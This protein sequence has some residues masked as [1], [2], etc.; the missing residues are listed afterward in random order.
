MQRLARITTAMLHKRGCVGEK[1]MPIADNNGVRIYYEVAGEGT[2]LV[3]FH[4]L[5]GSGSRWHDTGIVTALSDHYR[6]MLIDARGHGASDKPHLTEDYGGAIH[7]ADVLAV[8]NAMNLESAH[9][10]GHSLGGNV[11]LSLARMAPKRVQRLVIT[12][13]SPF[14]AAGEEAVE[15]AAWASDLQGGMAG[16]VRGYEARHGTL[17]ADARARWLEN[18]GAALAACVEAMITE[19]DGR[20]LPHLPHIASPTLYLVGSEEPFVAE[21]VRAAALMPAARCEVLPGLD[22]VQTFLRSDMLL[23]HVRSF[24]S[25]T[26]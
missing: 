15:M 16:F 7:A 25:A 9:I 22:H 14:P 8:L 24:L 19:A 23:P 26:S 21:A 1:A 11:A 13:Y 2:P 3:L 18:D 20:H 5:T 4:G 17:P 10:W 6:L 12:G